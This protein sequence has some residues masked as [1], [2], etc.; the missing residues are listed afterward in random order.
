M[1]KFGKQFRKQRTPELI[2][3]YIDYK[4]LKHFIKEQRYPDKDTEPL[5]KE[6][7]VQEFKNLLD[8]ELKKCRD[9]F[10]VRTEALKVSVNRRL[11]LKESYK[12]YNVYYL[13]REVEE[14][15]EIAKFISK[16]YS[17]I[18]LN[19]KAVQKIL[20]KFD[21]KFVLFETNL[22]NDYII[23]S[24]NQ[25]DSALK[26]MFDNTV[27]DQI[28]TIVDDLK[29]S[30]LFYYN[31]ARPE[32]EEAIKERMELEEEKRQK[33]LEIL[34][35]GG[36]VEK[37]INE[38]AAQL[39]LLKVANKLASPD[40]CLEFVTKYQKLLECVEDKEIMYRGT[41][42]QYRV[43]SRAYKY[44]NY[45]V[46][47]EEEV[48]FEDPAYRAEDAN[49][50]WNIWLTLIHTTVTFC[51]ITYAYP[52]LFVGLKEKKYTDHYLNSFPNSGFFSGLIF[53]MTPAASLISVF[54]LRAWAFRSYK[55]PMIFSTLLGILGNVAFAMSGKMR[56]TG[57]MYLG[58][59]LLGF[60][61]NTS[62]NRRYLSTFINQKQRGK[63]LLMFKLSQIVGG[64]LGQVFSVAFAYAWNTK[65]RR[66][67]LIYSTISYPSFIGVGVYALLFILCIMMYSEPLALIEL[68]KPE[69]KKPEIEEE[70]RSLKEK[71]LEKAE[72]EEI[73]NN[74][75]EENINDEEEKKEGNI[76]DRQKVRN[77]APLIDPH[78]FDEEV[79]KLIERELDTFG[80]VRYAV[81]ATIFF[82]F[83]NNMAI[84]CL[85]IQN[86]AFYCLKLQLEQKT[87][88]DQS[89]MMRGTA[90][91]NLVIFI[92]I[93]PFYLVNYF[94]ISHKVEKSLHIKSTATICIVLEAAGIFYVL[95]N[96]H[97]FLFFISNILIIVFDYTLQ[98]EIL[99]F[100]TKTVPT[101]YKLGRAYGI[102]LIYV[103]QYVGEFVGC[104]LQILV[105]GLALL[106]TRRADS[107]A[108]KKE[109]KISFLDI[110]NI[111]KYIMI[112]VLGVACFVH[113]IIIGYFGYFGNQ[114]DNTPLRR[115][116]YKKN[117][118]RLKRTEF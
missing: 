3:G 80:T 115:V 99:Y 48:H 53:S 22:K 65:Q 19:I 23:Y 116:V 15:T 12:A 46:E 110:E 100:Y 14:L 54:Y 9:F 18:Y 57:M 111:S 61:S 25:K 6:E 17:F 67:F 112:I 28:G 27:L 72:K 38:E 7:L 106:F 78:L 63:Y 86:P 42:D 47:T 45:F 11:Y 21:K 37:E 96:K 103:M 33:Q 16:M 8:R 30:L 51:M 26:G 82:T 10:V 13:T 84:V 85:F 40:D 41:K 50:Y 107:P 101:E 108:Y 113:I 91:I 118:I 34:S 104:F 97:W 70:K 35:K 39:L 114:F 92:L 93:I 2:D 36:K 94:V 52:T 77:D 20:K 59:A 71:P 117:K 81:W 43:I 56:S 62:L 44:N 4:A 55:G 74:D 58:R 29:E 75:N 69:E 98:D 32:E 76:L 31:I 102:T 90:L 73:I 60:A 89:I 66:P 105:G 79:Q 83:V 109:D 95:Q 68:S 87:D 88:D 24:F 1:V 49:C 5:G 64:V